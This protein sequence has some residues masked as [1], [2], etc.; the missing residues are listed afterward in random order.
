VN[1]Y[2]RFVPDLATLALPL[3]AL[4]KKDARFEWDQERQRAF[5]EIRRRL[6]NAPLLAYPRHDKVFVVRT[7]AS[8][9]G[10][11]AV[12]LQPDA[13]GNAVP[14]AYASRKLLDAET[15]YTTTEKEC[16]GVVWAIRDQFRP[17]LWGRQF[18]VET[19]HAALKWLHT[20]EGFGGR[21]ERWRMALSEYDFI[22]VHRRGLD[23]QLADALSRLPLEPAAIVA[24]AQVYSMIDDDEDH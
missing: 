17:Y 8:D 9:Y 7:D 1:Y 16:L 20:A 24:H 23:N 5:E 13:E 3:Y 22:V 2:R 14:V 6:A 15:R 11:G 18:V 21:I 4:T 10:I 12:L 19:D